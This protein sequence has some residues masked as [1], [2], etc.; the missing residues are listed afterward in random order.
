MIGLH[1]TEIGTV[2]YGMFPG[3][4]FAEPNWFPAGLLS[5]VNEAT[6]MIFLGYGGH[7][8]VIRVQIQT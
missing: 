3:V 8:G 2:V 6:L 1:G 7:T 4:T 5:H